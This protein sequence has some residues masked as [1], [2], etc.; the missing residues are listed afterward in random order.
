MRRGMGKRELG[1]DGIGWLKWWGFEADMAH[2]WQPV[3]IELDAPT[4][5]STI[6]RIKP[7]LPSPPLLSHSLPGLVFV[8]S[9]YT[10]GIFVPSPP[11]LTSVSSS[12]QVKSRQDASVQHS[13]IPL[14]LRHTLFAL[15]TFHFR[16]YV[17]CQLSETRRGGTTL[18]FSSKLCLTR[19]DFTHW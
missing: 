17:R 3:W 5:Y 14:S 1:C 7:A 19:I 9:Q 11:C 13:E 10:S 2:V 4:T 15:C 12:I 16:S 18:S 6:F 8:S